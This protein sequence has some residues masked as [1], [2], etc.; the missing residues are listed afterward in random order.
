MESQSYISELYNYLDPYFKHIDLLRGSDNQL[1]DSKTELRY[2]KYILIT[3]LYKIVEYITFLQ[4]KDSPEL[5]ANQLFTSLEE[6]DSVFTEESSKVCSMLLMDFITNIFYTH[7]D[8]SWIAANIDT[9]HL[10]TRL[11][12]QKEREKQSLVETL[13]NSNS[14]ERYIRM[15]KQKA[16]LSN[17]WADQSNK[18]SEYV[19]SKEYMNDTEDERRE[20]LQDIFQES[21][22]QVESLNQAQN[23]NEIQPIPLPNIQPVQEEEDGYYDNEDMNEDYE[24]NM[25]EEHDYQDGDNI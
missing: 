20:R 22:L 24:E 9:S 21:Q 8:P 17:W 14:D 16:G 4:I 18:A 6:R 25:Y 10:S 7:Y 19:S 15:E 3:I 1:F 13:D 12:K 11:S 2:M 23:N 5:D